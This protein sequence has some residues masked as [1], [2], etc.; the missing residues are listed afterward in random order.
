MTNDVYD[1]LKGV[2]T[3]VLPALASLY[4]GL[5]EI[6]ENLPDASDVVGTL[7]LVTVFLGVIL[8]VS[9]KQYWD[10]DRPFDGDL[11]VAEEGLLDVKFN[12]PPQAAV[13]RGMVILKPVAQVPETLPYNFDEFA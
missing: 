6:W 10:S 5:A 3:I 2:V 12:E 8:K 11:N 13:N 1:R 7:A 9:T 4:F